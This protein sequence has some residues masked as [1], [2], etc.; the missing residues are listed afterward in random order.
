MATNRFCSGMFL[1]SVSPNMAQLF[2]EDFRRAD[3]SYARMFHGG[4]STEEGNRTLVTGV[5]RQGIERLY[6]ALVGSDGGLRTWI[7]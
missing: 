2:G 6:R 3:Q 1:P 7:F 4:L 5:T